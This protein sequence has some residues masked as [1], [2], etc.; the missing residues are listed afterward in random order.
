MVNSDIL[1]ETLR[2]NRLKSYHATPGDVEEHRSAELRV[3]GDTAGRPLIE[4]IQ[5]ADDAMNQAQGS[6]KNRIKLILQNNN[7]F[8]A[9]VGTP[10]T[11]EGVEAICNL[12]R[13]PKIDRRVTIGNKG[14]G[15]KSVLTW[16]EKPSI[17]STTYAFTYDREKTAREISQALKDAYLPKNVPLMRLPFS[18]TYRDELANQLLQKGFVTVIILPIEPTHKLI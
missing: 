14:I 9:N 12:D 7:L 3:A 11:P 2:N 5:N 8:I 15:F 4:L 1:L 16:T 13:S 10:F 17:H 6:E 18:P